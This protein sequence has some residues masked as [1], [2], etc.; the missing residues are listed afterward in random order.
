[1]R[2][3]NRD[4]FTLIELMVVVAILSILVSIAIPNFMRMQTRV[5]QSEAK[6]NLKA[7]FTA[8]RAFFQN[9]GQYTSAIDELG[10]APERGNRYAYML[11]PGS[12]QFRN[13]AEPAP[14]HFFGVTVDIYAFPNPALL[15]V[16]PPEMGASAPNFGEAGLYAVG[17]KQHFM[18]IATSELDGL[19]DA[20]VDTWWMSTQTF[21]AAPTACTAWGTVNVAGGTPFNSNDDVTCE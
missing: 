2:R 18:A 21:A 20:A 14:G 12:L 15:P 5:K 4:G 17:R 9:N 3:H 10:F 16:P 8:E 6:M 11:G 1:M 13:V 7:I 19:D